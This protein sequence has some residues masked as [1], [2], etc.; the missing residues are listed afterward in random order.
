M[1]R[2]RH[3]NFSFLEL[4]LARLQIIHHSTQMFHNLDLSEK[5][6]KTLITES[7]EVGVIAFLI[8]KSMM[9]RTAPSL[10]DSAT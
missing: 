2:I 4:L 9:P 10:V 6:K 1:G 7:E 5:K 3:H 8:H